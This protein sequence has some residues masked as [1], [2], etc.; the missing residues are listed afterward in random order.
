MPS[1]A[2]RFDSGAVLLAD[3]ATGTN[4]QDMGI[5]PGVAPEEWVFEAPERVASLLVALPRR[6]VTWC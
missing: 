3:G 4:C 1:L 2:E 6:A 5:E